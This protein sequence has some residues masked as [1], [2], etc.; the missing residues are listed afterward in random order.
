MSTNAMFKIYGDSIDIDK[1]GFYESLH[2]SENGRFILA[3]SDSDLKSG[4]GGAR[5]KGHGRYVLLDRE[6]IILQGKLER[7]NDGKVSDQ[8][9]FV[10]NDWMFSQD[11][12]GTF[13]AFEPNGKQLI[14]HRCRANLDNNGIS[15]DGQYAVCQTYYSEDESDANKLF[16]FDL[17]NKKLVWKREPET[18]L[19]EDY[20][21]DTERQ[22]L[23][24]L[25]DKGRSYRYN[26]D[27][28]FLDAE[29]WEKER[30]NFVSGYELLTIAETKK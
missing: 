4:I 18:G 21:F 29:R 19:A 28:N 5:D 12:N 15:N 8:G 25:Y 6:K 7:P 14:Q 27:G 24:L 22:F 11:S 2:R 13:Y 20:H 16:F 10:L 26:F 17:R 3:W 30:I 23:Y 1:L 9:V